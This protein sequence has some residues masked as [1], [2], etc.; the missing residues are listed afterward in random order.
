MYLPFDTTFAIFVGGLIKI[1]VEKNLAKKDLSSSQ[2]NRVENTGTLVASG[3][4]AG[5]ALTGVLLAGLVFA[6]IPSITYYLF[7]INEFA[8]VHGPVGM[9]LS[10]II[11]L[12]VAYALIRIPLRAG[13]KE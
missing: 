11:F 12:T 13:D 10:L 5:E 4:I 9:I 8:F 1:L 3:F 7:G 2:R 6:G